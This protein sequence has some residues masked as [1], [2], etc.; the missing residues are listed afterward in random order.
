MQALSN[1]EYRSIKHRV[2]ASEKVERFS[3]AYFHCPSDDAVIESYIKPSIYR[4]FTFREFRHQTHKD[5]KQTGD[6]VGLSRF[7]A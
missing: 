7:L 2:V 5:V 6:K 4:S 3:V 1:G